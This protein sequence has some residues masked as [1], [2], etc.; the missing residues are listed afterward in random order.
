M[1]CSEDGHIYCP[2][3]QR[4][5]TAI[6]IEEVAEGSNNGYAFIHDNIEHTETDLEALINGIQ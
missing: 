4:I 1:S 5:I 6:N 2:V 3:C